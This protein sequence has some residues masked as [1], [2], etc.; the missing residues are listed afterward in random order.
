[1]ALGGA[2]VAC[3]APEDEN[4]FRKAVAENL[5][6]DDSQPVMDMLSATEQEDGV[7]LVSKDTGAQGDDW[8]IQAQNEEGNAVL[9]ST[10]P[11]CT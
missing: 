8:N 11:I 10:E 6:P 7:W 4:R 2:A 1:M 5:C 9:N 3:K